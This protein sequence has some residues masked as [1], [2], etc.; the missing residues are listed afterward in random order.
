MQV[1][2]PIYDSAFKYLMDDNKV[3]KLLLSAIIGEEIEELTMDVTEL[4][5]QVLKEN[6]VHS[7][8]HETTT[9]HSFLSLLRIDFAARIRTADGKYKE[10]LI[11]IQKAKM[12][13]DIMRFR[14]YLGDRYQNPNVSVTINGQTKALPILPIYFLGHPLDYSDATL[15]KVDRR[16]F[17]V[18]TGQEII[19]KEHF[20]ESLTHDS[21]IVQISKLKNRRRNELE[22][23]L[24]IFD[25]SNKAENKHFLDIEEHDLPEKYRVILRRMKEAISVKEVRDAMK[26][27][28]EV[29]DELKSLEKSVLKERAE[30]EDALALAE[31]ERTEKEAALAEKEK[32]RAE[33]ESALAQTRELQRKTVL[34][35]AELGLDATKISAITGLTP[36]EI[37]AILS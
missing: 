14:G 29:L 6:I 33:K 25:Q 28:D 8:E 4:K 12:P 37:S 26:M 34:Q 15:I 27:E 19:Q 20:I 36:A 11:E 21:F 24:S 23:L 30:K 1:I 10:I 2:N 18:I 17:D 9:V 13:T 16:Y 35:F 7:P 22:I 3:A 31:Q 5:T 32:E